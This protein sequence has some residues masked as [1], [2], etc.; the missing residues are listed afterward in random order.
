VVAAGAVVVDGCEAL[1]GS[2]LEVPPAGGVA[3]GI[4]A[5]AG[6]GEAG[7]VDADGAGAAWVGAGVAGAVWLAAGLAG[8][9]AGVAA[10]G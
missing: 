2:A 6:D 7:A 4:A 1:C 3:G 10:A 9:G 5:G 8:A